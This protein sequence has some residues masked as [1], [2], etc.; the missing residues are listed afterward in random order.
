MARRSAAFR[1]FTLVELLVVIAIIGILV[2]L[3]LPAIQAAREA[4]RNTECKNQL[5]NIALACLNY[6]SAVRALPPAATN[7]ATKTDNSIGWQVLILPYLEENAITAEVRANEA[8]TAETLEFANNVQL[9][10]YTCPSDPDID[11]VRGRKYNWA[12]VMSYS[13]V[14]GSYHS[15]AEITECGPQDE[16]VGGESVP[17]FG[18]VN[19]DGLMGLDFAVPTRRATDGLS[20]TAMIGERWYQLRTWTFGSYYRSRD[21]GQDNSPR[22]PRGP[23][24]E[25]AVSSAKN[26]SRDV[27]IN[28]NLNQ[29]GFYT[30]HQAEDRPAMPAGAPQPLLF[31]DLPFGSFHSG[32]ANFAFGDGSVRLLADDIDA[33]VYVALA[34]RNGDEVVAE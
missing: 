23:Q 33:D 14:L 4:A 25:T 30:L 13:G 6:E 20:N 15:R 1:A 18:P 2:A 3:L 17:V 32:G 5:R 31:N 19:L 27:P 24:M 26:I 22:P 10:I 7:A 28:A 11:E 29:T 16:C 8:E 21:D 34:S 12:G 9:D